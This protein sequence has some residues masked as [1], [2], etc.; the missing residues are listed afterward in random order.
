MR[1][2]SRDAIFTAWV[3]GLVAGAAMLLVAMGMARLMGRGWLF[4]MQLMT[5]LFAGEGALERASALTVLPG[6]VAHFTAPTF[7]WARVFGLMVGY[8]HRV[9]LRTSL[10]LGLAVAAL[11]QLTDVYL[12]M[13]HVQQQLNGEN[14]WARYVP[15]AWSWAEHLVFG[16]TLG[17]FYWRWQPR[18]RV[19]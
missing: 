11:A 17:L 2:P 1:A 18:P 15:P 8:A 12:F 6:V 16:A 19:G 14:L 10:L 7:F 3:S 5:A 9:P 13:P 4:P